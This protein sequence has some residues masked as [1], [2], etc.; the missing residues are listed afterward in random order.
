MRV[1]VAL[2]LGRVA[3]RRYMLSAIA[4]A[5]VPVLRGAEFAIAAL[6]PPPAHEQDT[7]EQLAQN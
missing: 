6:Q 2:L 7:G 1:R 4:A 3:V 5:I